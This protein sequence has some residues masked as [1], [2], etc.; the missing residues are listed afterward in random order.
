MAT[1]CP[2]PQLPRELQ[3]L[4]AGSWDKSQRS[5]HDCKVLTSQG[6]RSRRSRA[7]EKGLTRW[8]EE[9]GVATPGTSCLWK[10]GRWG[11][12]L[13]PPEGRQP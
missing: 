5:Q 2:A 12:K 13:R 3:L 6:G 10:P 8:P 9:G 4:I 7:G 1:C 11:R